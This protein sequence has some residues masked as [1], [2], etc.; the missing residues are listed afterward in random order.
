MSL[1]FTRA[2]WFSMY[3]SHRHTH[4]VLATTMQVKPGLV[5]LVN[6]AW[7]DSKK[8]A[9]DAAVLCRLC[10]QQSQVVM[11]EPEQLFEDLIKIEMMA[12]LNTAF[13]A[14]RHKPYSALQHMQAHV[15][16]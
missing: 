10:K 16:R 13:C 12:M 5:S 2:G 7:F 6:L 14:V 1:A 3:D 15:A 9:S 8:R 4:A 11:Q